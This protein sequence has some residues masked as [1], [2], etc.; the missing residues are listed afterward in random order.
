MIFRRLNS[1]I[2]GSPVLLW[3]NNKNNTNSTNKKNKDLKWE[4]DSQSMSPPGGI[5]L[6]NLSSFRKNTTVP[7]TSGQLDAFWVNLQGC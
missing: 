2:S 5:V 7:L 4:M 3:L 6:P 1:V